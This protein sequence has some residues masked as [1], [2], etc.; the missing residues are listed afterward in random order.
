V[1]GV[2]AARRR[3]RVS[4]RRDGY[5]GRGRATGQSAP[6]SRSVWFS[7]VTVTRVWATMCW[8]SGEASGTRHAE[9]TSPERPPAPTPPQATRGRRTS[10]AAPGCQA[11]D[12]RHAADCAS[13]MRQGHLETTWTRAVW[14][15]RNLARM[16]GDSIPGAYR[17]RRKARAVGP[18]SAAT[19]KTPHPVVR[20]RASSPVRHASSKYGSSMSCDTRSRN[21]AP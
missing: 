16:T 12:T 17:H 10:G 21:R 4:T 1:V 20:G 2:R 19:E 13:R 6:V 7:A 3:R 5:S 18:V 8:Q 11:G 9:G 15:R 14:A